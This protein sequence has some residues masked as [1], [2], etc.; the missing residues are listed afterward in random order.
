M[1]QADGKSYEC[2]PVTTA[3][4]FLTKRAGERGETGRLLTAVRDISYKIVICLILVV[5]H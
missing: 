2:A 3:Y 5:P 1:Y 4:D